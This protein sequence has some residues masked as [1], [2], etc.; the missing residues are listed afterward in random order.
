MT[1]PPKPKKQ[2]PPSKAEQVV[3][4]QSAYSRAEIILPRIEKVRESIKA[5]ERL[6]EKEK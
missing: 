6:K 2:I 1:P 5:A 4:S 3:C